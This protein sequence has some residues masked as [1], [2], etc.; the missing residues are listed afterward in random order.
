MRGAAGGVLIRVGTPLY[1]GRSLPEGVVVEGGRGW[2]VIVSF[3]GVSASEVRAVE[4]GAVDVAVA[5]GGDG[6]VLLWLVRVERCVD[7]SAAAWAPW[8]RSA[9][10][11]TH[12]DDKQVIQVALVEARTTRVRALR[13]IGLTERVGA[14]LASLEAAAA[15]LPRSDE[16]LQIERE[17]S[18]SASTET[19][20]NMATTAPLITGVPAR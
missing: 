13:T 4:R 10:E 2:I 8:E 14:T 6:R 11:Q 19:I 3:D 9:I 5:V 16:S 20:A 17:W 15:A 18:L 7:W 12:A 1:P